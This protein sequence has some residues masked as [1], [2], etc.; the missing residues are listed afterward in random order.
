MAGRR[1]PI[2]LAAA[3]ALLPGSLARG[4]GGGEAGPSLFPPALSLRLGPPAQETD[5]LPDWVLE[6][7]DGV[8][9]IG[10]SDDHLHPAGGWM[11]SLRYA[12]TSKSGNLQ[13]NT[14]ISTQDVFDLGYEAAPTD[15]SVEQLILGL[16][17]APTDRLTLT[18]S[19]PWLSKSMDHDLNPALTAGGSYTTESEG[20]GDAR[21]GL[22]YGVVT[23][24]HHRAH[25]NLG[26]SIP[27][28]STTESDDQPGAPDSRLPYPM[29]LGTGSFAMI[30]GA[31]YTGR[32]AGWS[33]G[34]QALY[35]VWLNQND[36]D[37]TAG[38]QLDISGWGA[39]SW[40]DGF[41]TSLRLKW[42]EWDDPEGSDPAIATL[43]DAPGYPVP[44]A[45]PTLQAG[46]RLDVG[47]GLNL[48]G[49]GGALRGNRLAVEF[50]FPV[51]QD[52]DGPQ[53]A[54]DWSLVA[55]WMLSF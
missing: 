42:T 13:D 17:Y 12:T 39:R 14:E 29:Q 21:L 18:A 40:S 24:E 55:G 54:T 47:L 46:Q 19:L 16:M 3:A 49:T 34:T 48:L 35:T 51:H 41:S 50:L 53:L 45:D 27:T 31:T 32:S 20:L 37:W 4:G 33:W 26:L 9:P 6:R 15:M 23:A 44:T 43:P 36:E 1:T 25:L 38:N 11:V 7:A 8:A 22:L 2:L 52:V 5:A 30:P 10:V 28:G